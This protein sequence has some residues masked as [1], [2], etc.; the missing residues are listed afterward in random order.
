MQQKQHDSCLHQSVLRQT[1]R[2]HIDCLGEPLYA[3]RSTR[4]YVYVQYVPFGTQ[5]GIGRVYP[6]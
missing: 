4:V 5:R 3:M 2:V 6:E 1:K